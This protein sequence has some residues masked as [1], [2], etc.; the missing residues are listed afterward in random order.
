MARVR[1]AA[2]G[3]AL[4][5]AALGQCPT[6]GRRNYYAEHCEI[7]TYDAAS[8]FAYAWLNAGP[9]V[10]GFAAAT[11][12]DVVAVWPEGA[13][14]PYKRNGP[15]RFMTTCV[16]FDDAAAVAARAAEPFRLANP[17]RALG[18]V[19]YAVQAR[20]PFESA[21]AFEGWGDGGLAYEGVLVN[22]SAVMVWE[23][24]ST[25]FELVDAAGKRYVMQSL[26]Q[27]VVENLAPSDLEALPRDLPEGWSF[28]SRT[29][30][31][32][33]DDFRE[34]L[35]IGNLETHLPSAF[36][37]TARPTPAPAAAPRAAAAPRPSPRP[38]PRPAAAAGGGDDDGG[39][40]AASAAVVP[41][42][43]FLVVFALGAAALHVR[44]ARRGRAREAELAEMDKDGGLWSDR[45]EERKESDDVMD[46]RYTD[47]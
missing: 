22:R 14:P 31:R 13:D 42:S 21:A 20:L 15:R 4:L 29:A 26:S 34:L 37:T 41:V 11:D 6:F 3:A 27:I 2:L 24:G 8:G 44:A 30:S 1:A 5:E 7:I 18:G 10:A 47:A 17:P 35:L 32:G 45:D 33:R 9:C 25:V 39:A 23:A 40:D 43:V 28:R 16:G 36:P 38:T 19:E 12:A 46:L